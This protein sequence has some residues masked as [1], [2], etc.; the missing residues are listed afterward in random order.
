MRKIRNSLALL[1][2]PGL[3]KNESSQAG[4]ADGEGRPGLTGITAAA[5]ILFDVL[6][7]LPNS[8]WFETPFD[9]LAP[10]KVCNKSGFRA[11]LYCEEVLE[12]QM[13]KN[14]VKS[15]PCM[16]HE[17]LNLDKNENFQV[18]AN[19]YPLEKI[20]FKNWFSV[21]PI[22]EYYY[23]TSNPNYKKKPPFLNGCGP[24][25]T[26][27]IE[28][29]YPKKNETILLPKNLGNKK[30]E[31]IFKLSHQREGSEVFWYLDD[32]FIGSTQ[33]IHELVFNTM[34]GVFEL[35]VVDDQ[36]YRIQQKVLIQ[37]ASN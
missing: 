12:L 19:C 2:R 31:V 24:D 13:P 34:P 18:N 16:Y 22:M 4:N 3:K 28:F 1:C 14:S 20:K 36:G 9:D 37:M 27:P 29:L 5:P 15:K 26:I 7:V 17:Q 6:Q 23:A 10:I 35:T 30:T 21:S 25:L 32:T 11:S 33:E 8:G